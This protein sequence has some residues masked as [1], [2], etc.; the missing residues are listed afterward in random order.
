[1]TVL[2]LTYACGD[3]DEIASETP[4]NTNSP[5]VSPNSGSAALDSCP[6]TFT[7]GNEVVGHTE[8][9]ADAV[10]D[11]SRIDCRNAAANPDIHRGSVIV[12]EDSP[13]AV[14]FAIDGHSVWCKQLADSAL[15]VMPNK[16]YL[17]QW[18][19]RSG[20]SSAVGGT[21]GTTWCGKS[22]VTNGQTFSVNDVYP[23]EFTTPDPIFGVT[24]QSDRTIV[25]LVDGELDVTIDGASLKLQPHT[26]VTIA[27]DGTHKTQTI[28]LTKDDEAAI[29]QLRDVTPLPDLTVKYSDSA[30]RT[31]PPSCTVYFRLSNQ[32]EST[33]PKVVTRFAVEGQVGEDTFENLS[34]KQEQQRSITLPVDCPNF[35]QTSSILKVDPDD[36]VAEKDEENNSYPPAGS[37]SPQP[38]TVTASPSPTPITIY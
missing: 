37:P 38:S 14:L 15:Q 21:Q 26:Q 16:S 3:G 6:L 5:S 12:T 30:H 28:V 19:A 1:M 7:T 9:G 17:I 34:P 13:A 11:V 24:I 29:A 8:A 20:S 18:F 10:E 31:D 27:K 36:F 4:A 35:Q 32:G 33:A 2:A 23:I 25:K 22:P